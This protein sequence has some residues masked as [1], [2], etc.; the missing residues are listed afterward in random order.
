MART[1]LLLDSNS[2]FRLARSIHPLLGQEFGSAVRYCLEVISELDQEFQRSPRLRS[3]FHWISEPEYCANRSKRR[4]VSRVQRQ[5][6]NRVFDFILNHARTERL[7]VS[8]VDIR[9]LAMA[10]VLK[11][12]LVTDDQ[13]MLTLAEAFSIQTLTTLELMR[14]MLTERHIDIRRVRQIVS[15]WQYE[16]DLPAGF[17]NDYHRLFGEKE[18]DPL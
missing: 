11:V 7:G 15:Y 17:H 12:Q 10:Y 1:T 4:L 8:P 2:Y 18:P 3:K 14:L 13:D 9:A 16:K 5:E 6:I